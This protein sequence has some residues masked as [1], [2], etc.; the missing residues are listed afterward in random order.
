MKTFKGL[1]LGDKVDIVYNDMELPNVIAARVLQYALEDTRREVEMK[2]CTHRSY[3]NYGIEQDSF[4]IGFGNKD[5]LDYN[6]YFINPYLDNCINDGKNAVEIVSKLLDKAINGFTYDGTSTFNIKQL[7]DKVYNMEELKFYERQVLCCQDVYRVDETN[8]G[9]W[10]SF[11][12][13]NKDD[14]NNMIGTYLYIE[15]YKFFLSTNL[16]TWNYPNGVE[17]VISIDLKPK[18]NLLAKVSTKHTE[19]AQVV[20]DYLEGR[21]FIDVK[22][23][24]YDNTHGFM[25]LND[26][27]AK[28]LLQMLNA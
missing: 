10:V 9:Y 23:T 19:S 11:K 7:L 22:N 3:Y 20:K 13:I 17:G 28:T 1:P 2:P 5:T 27:N 18:G 15:G 14:L 12:N 16:K 25:L 21:G 8:A 26:V 24:L 4:I 6:V